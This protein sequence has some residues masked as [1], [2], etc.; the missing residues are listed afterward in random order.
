M[1]YHVEIPVTPEAGA[2]VEAR[3]GGPGPVIGRMLERFKPEAIYMATTRRVVYMVVDLD[4]DAS[5]VELMLAGTTLA[6]T[7]PTFTPVVG[8]DDF[9]AVAGK[10]IPAAQAIVEG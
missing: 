5:V 9:P 8:A 3:P 4:D 2:A 6:G 1:K 7:Y 10:A